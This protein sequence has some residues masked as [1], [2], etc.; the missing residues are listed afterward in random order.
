MPDVVFCKTRREKMKSKILVVALACLSL[1]AFAQSNGSQEPTTKKDAVTTAPS[2]KGASKLEQKQIVHRDIAAREASTG[3]ATGKAAT[4]I[5]PKPAKASG[6]SE[7]AVK[8]VSAADLDGDG[9]A[10]RAKTGSATKGQA[11]V[12]TGDVNGDGKADAVKSS[13]HASEQKAAINNSHSNIKSPRDA[14]SGQA[15]GKR[16]HSDITTTKQPEADTKK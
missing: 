7:A 15:S 1:G 13:G 3:M 8:N 6:G 2:S 12:A 14:A 11:R 16:M 5:E 9:T 10:D 4:Q